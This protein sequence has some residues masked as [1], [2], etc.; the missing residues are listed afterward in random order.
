M[1]TFERPRHC[2]LRAIAV[3]TVVLA[4]L[5]VVAAEPA[6]AKPTKRGQV[7]GVVTHLDTGARW[8]GLVVTVENQDGELA[9]TQTTSCD[10]S[11]DCV[12][13]GLFSIDYTYTKGDEVHVAIFLPNCPPGCH[14]EPLAVPSRRVTLGVA[15]REDGSCDC[16]MLPPGRFA[17]LFR[18]G[19]R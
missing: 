15:C 12:A 8:Q 6:D 16:R 18:R 19:E 9:R 17:D 10:D 13:G 2:V 1:N 14:S 7:Q 11:P 3:I 4:A 5:V